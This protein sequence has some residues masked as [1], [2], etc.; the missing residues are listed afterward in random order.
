MIE[1]L[2]N[3]ASDYVDSGQDLKE[4]ISM[5]TMYIWGTEQNAQN[6]TMVTVH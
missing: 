6:G 3:F 1:S 4:S 5:Y 2:L